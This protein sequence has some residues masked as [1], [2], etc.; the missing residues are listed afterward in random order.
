ML[1]VTA[2]GVLSLMTGILA[3][4]VLA[5]FRQVPHSGGLKFDTNLPIPLQPCVVCLPAACKGG[6]GATQKPLTGTA[7]DCP[8][9]LA[10]QREC[11]ITSTSPQDISGQLKRLPSFMPV[12]SVLL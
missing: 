2:L 4:L 11:H 8:V 9:M 12:M 10:A 5:P 7:C 6:S 1:I 3:D